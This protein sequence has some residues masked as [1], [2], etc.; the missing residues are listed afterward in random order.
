[1]SMKS[2]EE[3]IGEELGHEIYKSPPTS[4]PDRIGLLEE[5]KFQIRVKVG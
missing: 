1:M 2:E 4:K 3:N 5:E